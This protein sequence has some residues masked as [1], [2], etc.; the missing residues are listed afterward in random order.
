MAARAWLLRTNDG[1]STRRN[2]A[3][4]SLRLGPLTDGPIY[5]GSI[6]SV[7]VLPRPT[8][9]LRLRGILTSMHQRLSELVIGSMDI[10]RTR[11]GTL[12]YC[13]RESTH[14]DDGPD[15]SRPLSP[16][17]RAE[18]WRWLRGEAARFVQSRPNVHWPSALRLVSIM[19]RLAILVG[20]LVLSTDAVEQRASLRGCILVNCGSFTAWKTGSAGPLTHGAQAAYAGRSARARGASGQRLSPMRRLNDAP[21][22]AYIAR[23]SNRWRPCRREGYSSTL[24][25]RQRVARL[26]RDLSGT[27]SHRQASGLSGIGRR[28]TEE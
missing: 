4:D 24:F 5:T 21:Q 17:Q 18:L 2:Q 26:L 12:L 27:H 20:G 25:R 16:F 22:R 15:P 10:G 3:V 7:C 9:T 6:G 8:R 11:S 13:N 1:K 19:A 14:F 23:S 28:R